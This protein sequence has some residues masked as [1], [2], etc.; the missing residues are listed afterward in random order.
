VPVEPVVIQKATIL[1]GA[2]PA[3]KKK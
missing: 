2:K 3:A 1:S